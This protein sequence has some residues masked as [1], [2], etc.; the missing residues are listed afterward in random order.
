MPVRE[1]PVSFRNGAQVMVAGLKLQ[2]ELGYCRGS[3]VRVSDP[4]GDPDH[5]PWQFVVANDE[6]AT[7]TSK[8][9]PPPAWIRRGVLLRIEVGDSLPHPSAS[10]TTHPVRR[11]AASVRNAVAESAPIVTASELADWRRAVLRILDRLDGGSRAGNGKSPAARISDLSRNE[12]IPRHIATLMRTV[13][14]MRNLVE[15]EDAH[16]SQHESDAARAAWNAVRAWEAEHN[17]KA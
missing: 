2:N 5:E 1:H 9:P 17:Q 6:H 13:T 16:L 11:P 10:P 7:L 4:T 14:E 8:N 12:K 15:Y 3:V